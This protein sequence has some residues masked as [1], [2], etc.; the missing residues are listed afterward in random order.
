[1]MDARTPAIDIDA[2]KI[3]VSTFEDHGARKCFQFG[4]SLTELRDIVLRKD[5][6]TKK[7]LPW[8]K[9]AT[10][11]KKRTTKGSL[12]HDD[13]VTA[14]SGLELD[15]DAT[16]VSIEEAVAKLR[17]LNVRALVYTSPS[18]TKTQ[19]KWRIVAP[20]STEL[21][22]QDRLKHAKRLEGA[23]GIAFDKASFA[24]S[25]SF[26][27]GRALDNGAPDHKA[28]VVNGDF[29]DQREDFSQF[30][31]QSSHTT[32]VGERAGPATEHRGIEGHLA[33]VGDGP[34]LE[35]FNN[36]L[37][38]ATG[39]CARLYGKDLDREALKKRLRQVIRAAPKKPERPPQEI[40][41]YL[42]DDY[43]DNL[44]AT[45]IAKYG[46]IGVILPDT[47]HM[48]RARIFR[49]MQRPNLLHYR[50]TFWDYRAG[51][52]AILDDLVVNADVWTFLDGAAA[53]R[54]KDR[55]QMP[56]QPNRITVG[57]TLAALK[58]LAILDPKVNSPSWLGA[59][60]HKLPPEHIISFPNGLLD[61][62]NN[63][64]HPPD[65]SFFT[66]AA[67]GF[68]YVANAPEPV[69]WKKFLAQIYAGDDCG[70][71]VQQVQEI[72]A[73]LLTADV[74]LEKAFFFIGPRRSG[75]G[76]MMRVLQH[77]LASTAVAG[78]T[79]KSLGTQFGLQPL[80]GK[81]VAIVDDLRVGSP[82][83][84]ESL[85]ENMLK[86]TGRGLF[87]ID[88]KFTTA[89][90]GALPIKLVFI[91]NVMP[92]FADDSGALASRF[93]ISNTT[94]SFYDKEDPFLFRDKLLP[95]L[96][97]IFHWSLDGLRRLRDRGRFAETE[98]SAEAKQR[99]ALL[100]SPV[101]GFIEA[102]CELHPDKSV[103]K[104]VIYAHWCSYAEANGLYR[105]GIEQFF[106][107]LYAAAGGKVHAGK[108]RDQGKQVPSIY[109]ID[110]NQGVR[111]EASR[112]QAIEERAERF[113]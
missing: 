59:S 96:P 15:Y 3:A 36:P 13:N 32:P 52:Y 33:M 64:L 62:R 34:G 57:E 71:E 70:G 87:T 11:G 16:L 12:R 45:A 58:A 83:D 25:Q 89:W 99:L 7:K 76:T 86:I 55:V 40:E 69:E 21:P 74:S 107:A 113:L 44:I 75:K 20:F 2:H 92:R 30:D 9:L 104:R 1:M 106:A 84:T 17:E 14:V 41:R 97:G 24:L 65:P 81:Q 23:L 103:P 102:K 73:Y 72:F 35:G 63:K 60:A 22:P 78:P 50:G 101:L 10:F 6:T 53:I 61:L 85:I 27:Y 54:G 109:G 51:A 46:T 29:V 39:A 111:D 100:G 77:L 82:K 112:Q 19:F 93:V 68:D 105:F 49:N 94:Q 42:G 43:L 88:R 48:G 66:T 110:M 67:L 56:F 80:I 79:L 28:F 90:E 47:D 8:L 5:A 108:K 37:R 95:E 4:W 31:Q 26:Y 18:N 38:S 98:A 91:S